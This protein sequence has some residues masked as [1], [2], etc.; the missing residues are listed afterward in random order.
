M[1]GSRE[2]CHCGALADHYERRSVQEGC[3]AV[4]FVC[5]WCHDRVRITHS[6]E[7][8]V[9]ILK[10]FNSCPCRYEAMN[11]KQIAGL[12]EHTAQLLVEERDEF[13]C[14]GCGNAIPV[15]LESW[16]AIQEQ[17]T[18]HLTACHPLRAAFLKPTLLE[19]MSRSIIDDFNSERQLSG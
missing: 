3:V 19:L 1:D 12:A 6:A 15:R 8:Y 18:A 16:P 9:E 13:T 7:P 2:L 4:R 10:H 11:L 17:V 5:E 14:R